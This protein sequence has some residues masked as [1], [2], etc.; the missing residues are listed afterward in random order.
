VQPALA[1]ALVFVLATRVASPQP[2]A[3]EKDSYEICSML[4]RTEMPA[5]WK[6]T[7]WAIRQ[8]TR[9]LNGESGGGAEGICLK[10]TPD[11]ES[12]YRPLI[13]DYV[14]KNKKRAVLDRKF[15]LP[16]YALVGPAEIEE[17]GKH[18]RPRPP[19][20]TSDKEKAVFPLNAT[21]IFHVSAVGFNGDRTRALVYVG[22]N[23]GGL[24]GGGA[25]HLL[26]NIDGTWQVD[27]GYHGTSC[28]WW[29]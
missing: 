25:Y 21:V 6:V 8:E 1:F 5:D 14:A 18:W 24:C 22:H 2:Q 12:I 9:T 7:G 4:L 29:S 26:V 13:Q 27:R 10:P 19:G 15:D 3:E 23:C 17:I 20:S 11:R 28:G 16:Q